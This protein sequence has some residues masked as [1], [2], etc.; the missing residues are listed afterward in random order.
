MGDASSGLVRVQRDRLT[1]AQKRRLKQVIADCDREIQVI[2]AGISQALSNVEMSHYLYP[3]IKTENLPQHW[4]RWFK[5]K[6]Q[7]EAKRAKL[8]TKRKDARAK[9]KGYA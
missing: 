8:D 6:A 3:G 4:N 5:Q 2:Q 7:L 9:L 1:D